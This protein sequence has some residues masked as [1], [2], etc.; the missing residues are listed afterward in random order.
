MLFSKVKNNNIIFINA[1][2]KENFIRSRFPC[3]SFCMNVSTYIR[4]GVQ[5][6]LDLFY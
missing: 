5:L 3:E 1:R 2:Q 4:T 6:K